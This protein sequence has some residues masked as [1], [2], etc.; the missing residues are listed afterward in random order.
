MQIINTPEQ[1]DTPLL[2]NLFSRWEKLKDGNLP[3]K[4]SVTAQLLGEVYPYCKFSTIQSEP[5]DVLYTHVGPAIKNL[6]KEEMENKRVSELFDPWI[7]KSVLES[8]EE[9]VKE[10]QATYVRKGISTIIGSLGYEYLILPFSSETTDKPE[11]FVTC[12]FP[13]GKDIKQA[14]DWENAVKDTPWLNQN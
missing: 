12:L 4:E 3:S 13:L 1:L 6:Y 10:A 7:R 14:E 11:Y 8:Y 2:Q 9:C 5:F